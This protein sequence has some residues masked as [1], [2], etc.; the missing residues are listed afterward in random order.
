M[1]RRIITG[2]LMVIILLPPILLGGIWINILIGIFG[3]IGAYEL[4]MVRGKVFDNFLFLLVLLFLLAFGIFGTKYHMLIIVSLLFS[5][6]LLAVFDEKYDIADLSILFIFTLIFALAINMII[7][8]Y[9]VNNYIM[10]FICFATF[11]TDVGAYFFGFFFGKHKLNER[12]SPKKTIEGAI[13]GWASGAIMSL[14]F[15]YF[16]LSNVYSLPFM[17]V[18]S[19]IL[20]V[21]SQI[22]DLS[23]SLLKRHYHIKDFGTIFP[24]H[25]GVLDRIDSLVACLAIFTIIVGVI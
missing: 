14:V 8:I 24:G 9:M 18:C 23:F 17:F 1:K 11:G 4:V 13:G 10:L 25:G 12:V 6:L 15:G 3:L 16:V 21:V 7:Q 5:L 20:P 2:I 22:G 19:L